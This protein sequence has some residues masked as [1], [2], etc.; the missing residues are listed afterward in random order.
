MFLFVM[1]TNK[2][3]HRERQPKEFCFDLMDNMCKR[4]PETCWFRHDLP[5]ADSDE[6]RQALERK[7]E[8]LRKKA[9]RKNTTTH[10]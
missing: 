8:Y 10:T 7:E 1:T 2:M 9:I 4:T 5:P 6:Y 3:S